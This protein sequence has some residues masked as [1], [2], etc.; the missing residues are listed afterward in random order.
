M[1]VFDTQT[2]H[3]PSCGTAITTDLFYSVN[4]DRRQDLRAAVIDGSFQRLT[5][6]NCHTVFRIDPAFNY[7]DLGRG[8]WIAV[9]P[10]GRLG[11]WESVEAED[12]ASFDKAYGPEAS[13]GAREIGAGLTV[14]IVF[15]WP[16]FREKL[17]AAESGLDDRE[18]ELL[19]LA[20]LR[21]RDG[22]PLSETVEL[23]FVERVADGLVL[24]WVDATTDIAAETLLVP[25]P[26][27][28][29]IAGNVDDWGA[30]REELGQ[31]LFV[32]MQ[33]FMI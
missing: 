12:R 21:T 23:R 33:R 1:S 8:Q 19:K 25:Q 7:L 32:D 10:F 29:D 13:G 31:G 20:I 15:G 18:L 27:Y 14:R 17:V 26:A 5:C 3:C 6:G 28:D 24:A 9:H 16:A 22:S 30:L 2:I 11:D 4:A